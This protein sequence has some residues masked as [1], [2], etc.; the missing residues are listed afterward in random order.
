MSRS[1]MNRV[2]RLENGGEKDKGRKIHF[3]FLEDGETPEEV[4]E[5][6]RSENPKARDDD[7]YYLFIWGGECDQ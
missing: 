4:S 5:R 7:L 1:L 3:I 6:Y 2:R